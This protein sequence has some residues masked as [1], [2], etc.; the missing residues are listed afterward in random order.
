MYRNT[1]YI[2]AG[3]GTGKTTELVR[4]ISGLVGKDIRSAGRMILTTYTD[5]AANSFREKAKEK[6]VADGKLEEAVAMDAA[7]IGTVHSLASMYIARY[8]HLL[9]MSPELKPMDDAV[10]AILMDRT[11]DDVMDGKDISLFNDYGRDF[12]LKL[13]Q[14]TYTYDYW[15]TLLKGIFE[16]VQAYDFGN[17]KLK[18]SEKA[19]RDLLANT[20]TTAHNVDLLKEF[21]ESDCVKKY[22]SFS[23]NIDEI[24][25][26]DRGAN[27][28][29]ENLALVNMIAGLDPACVTLK[30][31]AAIERHKWGHEVGIKPKMKAKWGSTISGK[32]ISAAAAELSRKLVPK[33]AETILEVTE[34]I[35]EIAIKWMDAYREAKRKMGAIDF[36]DMERM[37][38]DLLKKHDEVKADIAASVD[39][40][41]VDEF[42]DSNPI[43]AE[44]FDILSN[45][46]GKQS[47]FVGDQKQA[48]YGFTGSDSA[49]IS[50]LSA[51]FPKPEKDESSFTG[52]RKDRNG[53]SSQILQTS[54]RSVPS[55]VNLSNEVFSKSFAETPECYTKDFIPEDKV[56]LNAS[57]GKADP[58]Y[59]TIVHADLAGCDN[60]EQY[61]SAAAY[62]ICRMLQLPQFKDAGY[63]SSDVAIL[64]RSKFSVKAVAT[65]LAAREVPVSF[66]DEDFMQSAE[67]AFILCVLKLSAG[68]ATA[69][70]KAELRKIV[71]GESFAELVSNCIAGVRPISDWGGLEAFCK[72]IS[73]LSVEERISETIVRFDLYDWC[74]RWGNAAVRRGNIDTLRTVVQ[75]YSSIAETFIGC[76]DVRGFLS[77]AKDY[78]PESKFDNT[79]AGVKVLTYHK[80][81]GLEWKIAVLYDLFGESKKKHG[82][83]G[84]TLTGGLTNPDIMLAV[85]K[86][87]DKDWVRNC[88]ELFPA[89]RELADTIA[90]KELGEEKRLLYVGVT[91]AK[92]VLVTVGD[93]NPMPKIESLCPTA[94]NVRADTEK[95]T[96]DI[97]G[98]RGCESQLVTVTD[99]PALKMSVATSSYVYD[100]AGLYLEKEHVKE[101][102]PD[103]DKY[104]SPSMYK[105]QTLPEIT[106]MNAMDFHHRTDITH[107][108]LEDNEFGDCIHHIFARCKTEADNAP[109]ARRIL[110]VYGIGNVGDDEKL[111]KC[112][113]ELYGFLT[114][115]YGTPERIDRELPFRFTDEK[116]H[117]FSGNMDMVWHTA[118]GCVLVD[119]KTFPGSQ[120]DLFNKESKHWAGGYASQLSVYGAALAATGEKLKAKLLYYP[121]EGL[122]IELN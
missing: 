119:Y 35:F 48:I 4:I 122:V 112:I 76:A 69:K 118:D 109:A 93:G 81:K 17:A 46:V 102:H 27:T 52:Y 77:F 25:S 6:L 5:A 54:W 97:W 71:D 60:A 99:E 31:I 22:Q 21:A 1:H 62:F 29:R 18:D 14:D 49:L 98:V 65:A 26:S 95:G 80:A 8:W 106:V 85:P 73:R 53:N 96:R 79:S 12:G 2:S 105:D 108:D 66:V 87:P 57:D 83:S 111:A 107:K 16:K 78:K 92:D 3:A 91:R 114:E 43:Q 30:D 36:S 55:L 100:K 11:L 68:I 84:I 86:L 113:G 7:Q 94:R 104:I 82:I 115:K 61:A 88:I 70:T 58:E 74:G 28:Y 121:V 39:Y 44:I 67:V 40:L 9:G 50:E 20:L 59:K 19:T 116:G 23:V 45:T 37:F 117:V 63:T 42:Q 72:S 120:G 47:W 51:L 10:S 38:L 89:A 15:K 56:R 64:C 90:A 32:E 110:K 41:F 101:E 24:A 103:E 34:K 13:D 33:N 75:T